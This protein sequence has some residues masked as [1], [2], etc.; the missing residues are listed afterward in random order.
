ME[1]GQIIKREKTTIPVV[2]FVNHALIDGLHIA[3]FYS[4]LDEELSLMEFPTFEKEGNV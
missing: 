1:A 4:N 2:V 3:N